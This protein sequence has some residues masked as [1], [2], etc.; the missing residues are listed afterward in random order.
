M[1]KIQ[2]KEDQRL[3]FPTII[4]FPFG[5][6][7]SQTFIR[8]GEFLSALCSASGQHSAA[9]GGGHSLSEPVFMSASRVRGLVCS[10]HIII[11]FFVLT[12]L[13]VQKYIF[14]VFNR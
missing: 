4:P 10:F 7:S 5:L 3:L 1:A 9:V 12:F 2:K 6:F 13:R 8:H 11:V 14:F